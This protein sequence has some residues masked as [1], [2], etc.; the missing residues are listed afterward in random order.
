MTIIINEYIEIICMQNH[1]K[2]KE[3]KEEK[4]IHKEQQL[5]RI[6]CLFSEKFENKSIDI[7]FK[8]TNKQTKTK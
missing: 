1:Q 3:K 4:N 8:T 7:I 2:K 5:S 6:L